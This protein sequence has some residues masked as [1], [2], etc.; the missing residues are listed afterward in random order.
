MPYPQ[1]T[2]KNVEQYYNGLTRRNVGTTPFTSKLA[3][4]KPCNRFLD[5]PAIFKPARRAI[6][7]ILLVQ[8]IPGVRAED[9]GDEFS[10]NLFTDLGTD[11]ML[12]I[13]LICHS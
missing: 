7:V 3:N 10:N 6:S 11:P 5:L 4:L 9:S 1:T 8:I 12:Q 13:Y 2:V